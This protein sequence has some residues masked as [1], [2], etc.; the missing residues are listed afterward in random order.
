[1]AG[2]RTDIILKDPIN[3]IDVVSTINIDLQE[4]AEKSL[5]NEL[6][7]CQASCGTVVLMDVKQEL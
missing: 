7:E 3:G 6:T 4:A 2:K 1:M 5:R